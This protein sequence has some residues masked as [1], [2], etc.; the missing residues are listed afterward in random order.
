MDLGGADL[1]GADFTD[2]DLRGPDR[3]R[4][5]GGGAVR[6]GHHRRTGS[7]PRRGAAHVGPGGLNWGH[8]GGCAIGNMVH[9]TPHSG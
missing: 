5:A 9:V 2:T 4:S 8:H 7:V 3:F 6:C 1:R